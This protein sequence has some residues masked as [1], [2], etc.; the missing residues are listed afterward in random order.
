MHS[1][2]ENDAAHEL[3][4]ALAKLNGENLTSAITL[5]LRKRL[6]RDPMPSTAK[7]KDRYFRDYPVSRH[8]PDMPNRRD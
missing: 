5:A 6:A 8:I 7:P 3:A 1:N 4:T 2:I